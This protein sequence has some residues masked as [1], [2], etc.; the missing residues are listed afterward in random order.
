MSKFEQNESFLHLKAKE[1]LFV[2]LSDINKKND[3]C[4]LYP[5]SW[6]R[7]YGVFMELPFYKT[8]SPYYFEC[9]EGL[10]PYEERQETPCINWFDKNYNRGEI[11]F[12][13]D[14]TIFHKGVAR[15][16]VEVVHKSP[17][18]ESKLNKIKAFFNGHNVIIY[19]ISA[20]EILRHT[21]VPT[22]LEVLNI[23]D[24]E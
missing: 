12:V 9:S 10:I 13:P 15:I 8:D 24:I 4:N 20:Q 22:F 6:R 21:K 16:L 5:I 23:T 11:L 3:D 14:I 1:L 18:T 17:V 19:E 2:W 7:N